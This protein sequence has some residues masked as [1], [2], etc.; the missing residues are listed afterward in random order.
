MKPPCII[1]V[2]DID[3]SRDNGAGV[4][5]RAF[6][7]AAVGIS[8]M[9]CVLPSPRFSFRFHHPQV[10]YVCG[11]YGSSLRYPFHVLATLIRLFK[12]FARYDIRAVATRLGVLP[13]APLLFSWSTGAPLFLKTHSGYQP[14]DRLKMWDILLPLN[15]SQR[16]QLRVRLINFVTDPVR[17]AVVRRSVII[18]TP[19]PLCKEVIIWQSKC[20]QDKIEIIPNGTNAE[21]FSP[22]DRRMEREQLGVDRWPLIVGYVG[23][24][25]RDKRCMDYLVRTLAALRRKDMDV[26]SLIIGEGPERAVLEKLVRMEGLTDR[27]RF[28]GV[29]PHEMVPRYM[30]TFDVGVDL[31]AA[32]MRTIGGCVVYS[33]YSQKMAQYLACG[34]PVLAW[35]LADTRFLEENR[36][37]FLAPLHDQNRLMERLIAALSSNESERMAIRQRAREYAVTQLSYKALTSA[38][39]HLW[40]AAAGITEMDSK[41]ACYV[42]NC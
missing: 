42:N 41:G 11:H 27:V 3:I 29:V 15:R 14:L 39:L 30:A 33:A 21:L 35:D 22:R 6:V 13:L 19:S 34:I 2:T 7:T 9:V 16:R 8:E 28:V 40:R 4:N 25:N 20:S 24:L 31:C 32:P 12:L 37:G 17:N 38:R 26:G 10:E 5:E 36:I 1:Y 23:A 18:D